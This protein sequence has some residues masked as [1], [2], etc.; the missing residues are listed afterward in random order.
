MKFRIDSTYRPSGDQPA[1]IQGIAYTFYGSR[2]V[3]RRSVFRIYLEFH[4][5]M[6]N[7]IPFTVIP[8]TVIPGLTGNLFTK[9][10]K[11]PVT[12]CENLL[13]LRDF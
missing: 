11:L 8:F 2:L 5:S 4:I 6:S 10:M 3:S 9:I 12:L 1:A 13:Y 7:L